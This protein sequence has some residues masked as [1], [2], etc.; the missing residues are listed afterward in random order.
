MAPVP[1]DAAG[2]PP[3]AAPGVVGANPVAPV[4]VDAP[5]VPPGV[6]PGVV[7]ANPVAPV[8]ID[9]AGVPPGVVPGVVGAKPVAP[10][11]VDAAGVPPGVV[12][13]TVGADNGKTD[14]S[15]D[16]AISTE[17]P[18][19]CANFRHCHDYFYFQKFLRLLVQR[20]MILPQESEIFYDRL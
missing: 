2:V 12:P 19:I 13:G 4:P 16:F 20:W 11:P 7:G 10:V 6:V 5:G 8:S 1:V 3:G 17:A 18:T 14:S 9:A 15:N